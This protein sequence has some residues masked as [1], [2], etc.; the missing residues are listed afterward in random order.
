MSE[1]E[2]KQPLP[3]TYQQVLA[4]MEAIAGLGNLSELPMNLEEIANTVK[5]LEDTIVNPPAGGASS[6]VIT[7]EDGSKVLGNH[8][9]TGNAEVDTPLDEYTRGVTFEVKNV[10]IVGLNEKDGMT[11]A[12]C[13]V[14]TVKRDSAIE[15]EP[16]A[17]SFT[18]FQVAF[19]T[20]GACLY[21]RH[22]SDTGWDEWQGLSGGGSKEI[23]SD[24]QPDKQ[25][26]GDYWCQPITET[27]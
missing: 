17:I 6:D 15:D 4:N 2:K 20:S 27:A 5:K 14:M 23:V 16:E 7:T 22:Q 12:Y 13:M 1:Q 3:S 26:A 21:I 24:T 19:S 10:T 8:L 18:P 9:N 25:K 11:D